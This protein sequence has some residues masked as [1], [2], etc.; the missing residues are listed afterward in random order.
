MKFE[1]YNC[2][3]FVPRAE[4]NTWCTGTFKG[5]VFSCDDTITHD[6]HMPGVNLPTKS[7][8]RS[9][10]PFAASNTKPTDIKKAHSFLT[11]TWT[12]ALSKSVSQKMFG[13]KVG[14]LT[15]PRPDEP[16]S[17]SQQFVNEVI[18]A[19]RPFDLVLWC[20]VLGSITQVFAI[21]ELTSEHRSPSQE[22]PVKT[23][24]KR[25]L[26]ATSLKSASESQA[27]RQSS[28]KKV[29]TNDE[30]LTNQNLPLIYMDCKDFRIFIPAKETCS[31]SAEAFDVDGDDSHPPEGDTFLLQVNSVVLSPHADNPLQRLV[32]KKDIYRYA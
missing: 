18:V 24:R 26:S 19:S 30:W 23:R 7:S 5:V 2:I 20:P 10:N 11:F 9:F 1:A 31:K 4:T 8:S 16:T 25:T 29:P 15:K 17:P 12:R 27:T 3:L 6:T 21:D 13:K 32:V 14:T 28:H 22:K